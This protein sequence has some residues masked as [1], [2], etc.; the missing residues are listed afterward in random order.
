[1]TID[2]KPVCPCCGVSEENAKDFACNGSVVQ[3]GKCKAVFT[4]GGV[5]IYLGESYGVVLPTM[6]DKPGALAESIYYDL[7][8][9][10]SN[11]HSRR[12]GWFVPSSKLIAQ[13]G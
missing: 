8:C 10:G 7:S 2:N 3:C 11:G 4:P 9:L 12:H 6:T 5:S 1:M 13:V